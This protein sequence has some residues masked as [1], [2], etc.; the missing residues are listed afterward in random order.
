MLGR[1]WE[2]H[3]DLWEGAILTM[4]QNE[5]DAMCLESRTTHHSDFEEQSRARVRASTNRFLG[6]HDD[7]TCISYI[8]RLV[9]GRITT[10]SS[11]NDLEL[12]AVNVGSLRRDPELTT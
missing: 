7:C 2:S 10:S 1:Y 3:A 4:V 11:I 6:A 5:P 9:L 8:D 12:H